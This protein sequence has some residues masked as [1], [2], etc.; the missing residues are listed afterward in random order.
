MGTVFATLVDALRQYRLLDTHQLQQVAREFPRG[1]PDPKTVA[2]ELL[3]RGWL[4]AYQVNQL[5]Q[6]RAADLSLGSY[7]LLE[8][9]GGKACRKAKDRQ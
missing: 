3:R 5:L 6:D 2:K 4:T 7:V 1:T 9:L 8:R